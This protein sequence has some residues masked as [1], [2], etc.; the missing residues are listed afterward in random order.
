MQDQE[1][2]VLVVGATGV[3]G[4]AIAARLAERGARLAVIGR[5]A[6]R[7][8]EVAERTGAVSRQTADLIDAD[9]VRSAVQA[10]A[11][12]LGGLDGLVVAAGVAAFGPAVDE[13]DA[14]VEELFAVNTLGV[15]TAVRSAVP[16]LREGGAVAVIS[17]VLADV[18]TAGMAAYSA[19]KAATAT[20]LEV[21]RRELR[22]S[23]IDVLDAR[24]PHLETG[25]SDRALAGQPPKLP[26]GGDIDE[27]VRLIVE[28]L[29]D[30]R[31]ELVA[32]LKAGTL[33]LR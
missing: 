19:S 18:P 29:Y 1:P 24:P 7:L 2:A 3:L 13:D 12:A 10:S 25:L 33:E 8:A 32:D 17:A 30:G 4:Q 23:R 31:R 21:L 6:D 28:G 5:D 11:E 14:V 16:Q 26:P 27:V 20:W 9:A 15:M 22:R